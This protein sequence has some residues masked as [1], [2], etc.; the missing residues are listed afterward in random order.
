VRDS[1]K[2]NASLLTFAFLSREEEAAA[3][4]EEFLKEEQGKRSS[5]NIARSGNI[6]EDRIE[7]GAIYRQEQPCS[8]S[9]SLAS[10]FASIYP[11]SLSLLVLLTKKAES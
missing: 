11:L 9:A 2:K 3:E 7:E 10:P 5:N 4:R 6:N 1:A 8:S